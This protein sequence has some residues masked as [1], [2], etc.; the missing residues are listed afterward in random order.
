MTKELELVRGSGN[1]FRDFGY[2]EAEALQLKAKMAARIL[3]LREDEKLTAT[4]GSEKTGVSAADFERI[5]NADLEALSIEH[6]LKIL[7]SL[8]QKVDLAVTFGDR[9]EARRLRTA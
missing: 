5:L 9:T 7:A 1:V 8:G 6:M 3:A 2:L 4:P